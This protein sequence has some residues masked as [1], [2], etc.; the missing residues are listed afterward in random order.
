MEHH[1]LSGTHHDLDFALHVLHS[2]TCGGPR[3]GP[4]AVDASLYLCA[5]RVGAMNERQHGKYLMILGFMENKK[6]PATPMIDVPDTPPLTEEELV[7][8]EVA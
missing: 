2:H 5:C 4:G 6:Q 7:L 8:E 3:F 1:S